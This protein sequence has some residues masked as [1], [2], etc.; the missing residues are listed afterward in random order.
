MSL[1]WWGSPAA[2]A[3]AG[4]DNVAARQCSNKSKTLLNARSILTN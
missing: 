1:L 3:A 2:I 4:D